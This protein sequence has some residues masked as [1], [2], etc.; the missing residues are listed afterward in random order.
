MIHMR[1]TIVISDQPRI[2]R[3]WWNGLIRN[4]RLPRV[5]LK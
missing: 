5:S 3:W 4:S 1:T 2:S